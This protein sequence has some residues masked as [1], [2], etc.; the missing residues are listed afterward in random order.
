[1]N[2]MTL[3]EKCA[4]LVF[5]EFRFDAPDYDGA[6]RRA[7]D[8]GLGGLV[9]RG[10]SLFELGPFVNT[11]QKNA[12]LPLLVA[13]AY[14]RG[15]GA[16]VA[17]ATTFPPHLAVAAA[18]SEELARSKGRLTARE[19]KAMGVRWLLGAEPAAFAGSEALA[20]A[21]ADGAA[22][23]KVHAGA[24]E[25]VKLAPADPE[26]A[27]LA[28]EEDVQ[29][30]RLGDAELYRLVENLLS[31]KRRLGLYGDRMTDQAGAEKVVGAPSHKAAAE[32]LAEAAITR[33]RD[34]AV[35]GYGDPRQGP[36]P[37]VCAWG[38]DEYSR[39]AAARALAGEIPFAGRWPFQEKP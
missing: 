38:D 3:R 10:G 23:M 14:D 25:G 11:L 4:Q 29:E 15:A 39:R 22:E 16:E 36:V 19:A 34:G 12:K 31:L 37:D 8:L 35:V 26:E 13:A 27:I 32:K 20:R 7:K 30:G 18:G 24:V 5:F 21:Y 9:V 28:L 1:M 17:Q 6:M 33:I 2:K